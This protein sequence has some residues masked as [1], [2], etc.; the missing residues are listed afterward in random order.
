VRDALDAGVS[1]TG[2]TIHIVDNGVDTGQ[3]IAQATVP[4]EKDDNEYDLHERIKIVERK[5]LVETVRAMAAK[6]LSAQAAN[7]G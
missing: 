7:R 1:E 2:V 3:Q 4:V 6:K 5:L